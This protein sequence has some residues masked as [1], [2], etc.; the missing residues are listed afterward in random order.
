M[1]R[2]H[3]KGLEA[4]YAA[5][6]NETARTK[7]RDEIAAAFGRMGY[8]AVKAEAPFVDQGEPGPGSMAIPPVDFTQNTHTVVTMSSGGVTTV[9]P[10]NYNTV[11][12]CEVPVI[13]GDVNGSSGTFYTETMV[14]TLP[15]A[16]T[17]VEQIGGWPVIA[18]VA[19][20]GLAPNRRSLKGRVTVGSDSKIVSVERK[21]GVQTGSNVKGL[22]VRAGAAPLYRVVA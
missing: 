8:G 21:P 11:A 18:T 2:K 12:S 9:F 17:P 19:I 5:I 13:E 14:T 22:L 4:V 6:P 16:E 10:S 15:A 3:L 1:V 20:M 7:A